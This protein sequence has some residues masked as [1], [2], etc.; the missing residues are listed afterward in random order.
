MSDY[1]TVQRRR[2][3]TVGIFVVAAV[4]ALAWLIYQFGDMPGFISQHRSFQVIV[5]F[6][7]APGVQ[8]DTPVR[9]CGYQIG[10]VTEVRH[11]KVMKDLKTGKFYHQTSVVLSINKKYKDIPDDVEAKLMTRGLGSSYIEL[12][13]ARFDVNEPTGGC[14]VKGSTLQG[15]TGVTSEFFPAESQEKLDELID[16]LRSFI[17]NTN[18]IVGDPNTRG[19]LEKIL[20]NL[21]DASEHAEAT[22][23]EFRQFAASGNKTFTAMVGTSEELSKSAAQLRLILEKINSG[24]GSAG[25][26]INDGRLY[27]NLLENSQQ[28]EVL[29]EELKSFVSE[30]REKGLRVK[31]K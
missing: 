19:N 9:F 4:C 16:G 27:E 22:I 14:L 26:I 15:S 17:N 25:R 11:P 28:M 23:E 10:R 5:Q 21:A 30:A 7:T 29:L 24:E 18:T 20:A 13:L 31:L 6:P 12:K 3:I 2:N 1:E 8:R